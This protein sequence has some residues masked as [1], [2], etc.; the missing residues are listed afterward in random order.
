MHIKPLNQLAKEANSAA[1]EAYKGDSG[2]GKNENV[3]FACQDG[4]WSTPRCDIA[5]CLPRRELALDNAL[6]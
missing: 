3:R 5:N 4:R 6:V 1:G 2:L